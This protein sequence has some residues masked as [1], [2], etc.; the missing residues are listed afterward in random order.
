MHPLEPDALEDHGRSWLIACDEAERDPDSHQPGTGQLGPQ[1]A[2]HPLLL[3]EPESY[4][5]H[6]GLADGDPVAHLGEAFGV[7]FEADGLRARA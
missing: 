4:V 2:D 1:R 7:T 5:D 3:R 6:V